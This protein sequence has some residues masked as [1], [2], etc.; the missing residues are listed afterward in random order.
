MMLREP[1]NIPNNERNE[2]SFVRN[3]RQL[4]HLSAKEIAEQL[5]CKRHKVNNT[6]KKHNI[7]IKK[8]KRGGRQFGAV[9]LKKRTRR[10]KRMRRTTKVRGALEF[11]ELHEFQE[12]VLGGD[13]EFDGFLDDIKRDIQKTDDYVNNNT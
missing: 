9:D 2:E 11:H 5:G 4:K 6:C 7:I 13:D 10:K 12:P 1:I 3:V 8:E